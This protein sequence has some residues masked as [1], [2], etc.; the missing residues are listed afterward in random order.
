MK[1]HKVLQWWRQLPVELRPATVAALEDLAKTKTLEQF[2]KLPHYR[3]PQKPFDPTDLYHV[4][5]HTNED[6]D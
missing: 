1:I 6:L 3:L 5:E 4:L 2:A